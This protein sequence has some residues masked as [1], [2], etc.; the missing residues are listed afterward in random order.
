MELSTGVDCR[1]WK[2]VSLS[3]KAK[4]Q[5][6]ILNSFGKTT[7]LDINLD[8]EVFDKVKRARVTDQKSSLKSRVKR[9]LTAP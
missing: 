4:I 2:V 9:K 1:A 3:D 5:S 7:A 6:S 8:H